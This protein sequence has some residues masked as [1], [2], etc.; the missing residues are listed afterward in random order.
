MVQIN[1]LPVSAKKKR[2][3]KLDLKIKL[4][5]I[6]FILG[7]LIGLI[8]VAWVILGLQ[9]TAQQKELTKIGKQRQSLKFTLQKAERLKQEKAKL[10]LKLDF[11]DRS[12]NREILWAKNLNRLSNLIP[13]GIWLKSIALHSEK[14]QD[15]HKYVKLDI[16][17]SAVSLKGEEMIDL[18][19]RFMT[20]IKQDEVFS[21]QFSKVELISS[22]RKKT[23]SG[24]VEVM[25]FK[26]FAKFK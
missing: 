13:S 4:G 3:V 24:K 23:R 25:D 1:L 18:I 26:L 6:V 22:V 9:F 8:V 17:G 12:I 19:G 15:L 5:P 14:E 11:L 7:A 2:K 20:A 21:K 16:N 10:L